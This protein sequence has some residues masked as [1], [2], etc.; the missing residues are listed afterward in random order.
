MDKTEKWRTKYNKEMIKKNGRRET[1][2]W[3]N[4]IRKIIKGKRE[5][6]RTIIIDIKSKGDTRGEGGRKTKKKK[7][8]EKKEV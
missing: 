7:K 5:K 6:R 3:E 1:E 4:K 8:I 2:E